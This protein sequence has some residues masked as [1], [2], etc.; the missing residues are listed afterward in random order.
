MKYPAKN[1]DL[2]V[3]FCMHYSL[4]LALLLTTSHDL[5][6]SPLEGVCMLRQATQTRLLGS[7]STKDFS[8]PSYS[9][10][11]LPEIR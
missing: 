9:F 11:Q 2:S 4:L 8:I 6:L 5:P 7:L 3:F 10:F 1:T